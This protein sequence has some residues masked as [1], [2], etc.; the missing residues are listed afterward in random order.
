M[1]A[2]GVCARQQGYGPGGAS[3][4]HGPHAKEVQDHFPAGE[5][6]EKVTSK[7][8]NLNNVVNYFNMP[9]KLQK[10]KNVFGI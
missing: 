4:E 10:L 6:K 7:H 2:E 3:P 5:F 1:Q 9:I 8:L